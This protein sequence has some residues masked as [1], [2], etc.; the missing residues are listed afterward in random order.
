MSVDPGTSPPGKEQFVNNAAV[1]K[2]RDE[3][4]Y[5]KFEFSIHIYVL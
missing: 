3:C 1:T 5:R 4:K 2:G